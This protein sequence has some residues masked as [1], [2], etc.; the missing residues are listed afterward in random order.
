MGE[1]DP[2]SVLVIVGISAL[3][4]LIVMAISP[5][6][7]IP[8]VVV[9]LLLGIAIGPEALDLAKI[10]DTTEFLGNLGLGM[11]F[12]FAGYEIDF[13]R[14][15]GAP[16]KLGAAAWVLSLAL[17]YG[18]GGALAAAGIV[19]LLPLHGLGDGDDGDRHAD[20]DPP[21]RRRAARPASAPT[22]SRAA[23]WASSGR[24]S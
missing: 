11:L 18:I 3:A 21:R 24:S 14:I 4:G 22:C 5:R 2:T 9:E 15:K 8:V 7:A 20:P 13:G 19:A 6:L 10:D 12:F 17:A 1:V 16:L 23:R